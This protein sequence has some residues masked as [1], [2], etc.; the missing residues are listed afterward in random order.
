M[1]MWKS[2]CPQPVLHRMQ[3]QRF[4]AGF[5]AL[6]C[7]APGQGYLLTGVMPGLFLDSG[8]VE[9]HFLS[10]HLESGQNMGICQGYKDEKT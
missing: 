10:L 5:L 9:S 4:Q 8:H 6:H 7:L 3:R 1:S 2:A